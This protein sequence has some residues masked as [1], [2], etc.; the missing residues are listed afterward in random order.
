MAKLGGISRRWDKQ[1]ND[2]PA[3]S[4]RAGPAPDE[5]AFRA[6]Y[7]AE[8][9]YV[10]RSLRRLGVSDAEAEDLAHDVFVVVYR[11][12]DDY[13]RARP[14]RPWLF[15][16]ALR[17]AARALDR[18][19]RQLELAV[20][21]AVI[22]AAAAPDQRGDDARDLLLRALA[23]LEIDQRVVCILHDLDGQ[24]APEIAAA[25]A[26]PVNTV[27]SRLRVGRA[28][29]AE[30][31]RRWPSRKEHHDDDAMRAIQPDRSTTVGGA[32]GLA[33][34]RTS[35]ACRTRAGP[36]AHLHPAARVAGAARPGG[37]GRGAIGDG[38]QR[39][40]AGLG[41]SALGGLLA[42]LLGAGTVTY[43]VLRA[44]LDPR[45]ATVVTIGARANAEQAGVPRACARE[46]GRAVHGAR[47]A[48]HVFAPSAR[49]PA[50]MGIRP[51][52]WLPRRGP[53]TSARPMPG[54]RQ[55]PGG[56]ASGR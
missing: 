4:G 44:V 46:R 32:R 55:S 45:P 12:W 43:L 2:T 16:I 1:A 31:V 11:R 14:V 53:R 47:P 8:L 25:L 23:Q 37:H 36:R 34:D 15:G 40:G 24:A 27:Y 10:L 29:L 41:G 30:V 26:L 42:I 13:D 51:V 35:A 9:P 18:H 20:G 52:R 56:T 5:R 38:S 6:L 49:V 50:A 7:D 48:C 54:C 17:T 19:W 28:R 3:G 33:G 21:S 39:R 22:E